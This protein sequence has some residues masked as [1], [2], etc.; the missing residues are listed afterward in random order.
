MKDEEDNIIK[1]DN[2]YIKNNNDLFN[3]GKK[4]VAINLLGNNVDINFVS[5]VIYFLLDYIKEMKRYVN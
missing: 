4:Y 5:S 1:C 3:L 2:G